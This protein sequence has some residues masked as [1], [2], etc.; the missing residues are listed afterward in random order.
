[1]FNQ[2]SSEFSSASVYGFMF[3]AFEFLRICS[4]KLILLAN[5]YLYDSSKFL[6]WYNKIY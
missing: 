2:S 3:L 5:F 4:I 6:K 1:M